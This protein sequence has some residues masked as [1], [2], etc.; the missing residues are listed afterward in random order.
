MIANPGFY[1][2]LHFIVLAPKLDDK[3]GGDIPEHMNSSLS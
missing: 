3:D 2:V 1:N